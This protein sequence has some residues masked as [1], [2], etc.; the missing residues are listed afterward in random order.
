MDPHH[1]ITPTR[2]H[3][4]TTAAAMMLLFVAASFGADPT[5]QANAPVTVTARVDRA[6]ITIGDPIRY[7]VE[8]SAAADTEV[9]IPVLSGS[10][11]E[12]AISDF[13]ELPSRKENGLAVAERG[14]DH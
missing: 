3:P 4:V 2:P 7:T 14:L 13:G 5:P 10:L 9:L 1:P 12:F 8:V 11:G 6:Q